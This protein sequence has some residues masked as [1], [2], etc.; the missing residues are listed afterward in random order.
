MW[1]FSKCQKPIHEWKNTSTTILSSHLSECIFNVPE[2][3]DHARIALVPTVKQAF[4]E[5][6]HLIGD[7]NQHR[8]K[9]IIQSIRS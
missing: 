3:F 2:K 9:Q 8:V 1:E 4:S 6:V 7:R 5:T